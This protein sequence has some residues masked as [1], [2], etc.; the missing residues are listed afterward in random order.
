MHVQIRAIYIAACMHAYYRIVEN[1]WGKK[2]SRFGS[3]REFRGENFRSFLQSDYNVG[4]ITD[5][6]GENFH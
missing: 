2:L 1:F 3:K 5:F 6:C 4:T